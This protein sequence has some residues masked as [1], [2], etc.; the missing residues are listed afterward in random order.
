MKWFPHYE[1]KQ[2]LK[3]TGNLEQFVDMNSWNRNMN[4]TVKSIS[5]SRM[6]GTITVHALWS[7]TV[8]TCNI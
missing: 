4:F 3:R 7:W 1:F 5:S 6:N 2:S 8:S